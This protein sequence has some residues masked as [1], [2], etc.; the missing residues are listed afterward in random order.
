MIDRSDPHLLSVAEAAPLLRIAERSLYAWIA[1]GEC[2]LPILRRGRRLALSTRS[3]Q[4]Y[5][6]A[7]LLPRQV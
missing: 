2:P 6:A 5:N 1:S 4:L 7:E 3:I